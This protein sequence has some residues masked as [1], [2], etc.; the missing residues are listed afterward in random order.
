MLLFYF[1]WNLIYCV[2]K[3][4]HLRGIMV[5]AFSPILFKYITVSLCEWSCMFILHTCILRINHN[6]L[7]LVICHKM[8]HVF[9]NSDFWEITDIWNCIVSFRIFHSHNEGRSTKS[10]VS[11]SQMT[12]KIFHFSW[13]CLQNTWN[14]FNLPV[15]NYQLKVSNFV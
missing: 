7:S 4:L 3:S 8:D 11:P 1:I 14:N 2:F 15:I 6:L 9:Q 13:K 10:F 5:S 12:C